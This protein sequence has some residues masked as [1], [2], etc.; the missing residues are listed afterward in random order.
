[1]NAHSSDPRDVR[2][3]ALSQLAMDETQEKLTQ[4]S[5]ILKQARDSTE[6]EKLQEE[7]EK[8]K[9]Q[10]VQLQVALTDAPPMFVKPNGIYG[11]FKDLQ[12]IDGSIDEIG[13][14][15]VKWGETK[16]KPEQTTKPN[17]FARLKFWQNARKLY[18][19]EEFFGPIKNTLEEMGR[20][21]RGRKNQKRAKIEAQPTESEDISVETSTQNLDSDEVL[22]PL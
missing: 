19:S 6:R 20:E 15:L 5:Q 17:K 22:A 4:N 18:L 7:N 12:I 21:K 10:L 3:R 2:S 14:F 11:N 8:L 9:K 1:M 16:R 13:K